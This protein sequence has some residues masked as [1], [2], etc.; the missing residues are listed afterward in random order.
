M[1]HM[2]SHEVAQIRQTAAMLEPGSR[3]QLPREDVLRMVSEISR[4]QRDL[5]NLTTGLQTLLDQSS[6][7]TT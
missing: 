3:T 7:H 2:A 6:A 5:L 1:T 4:L